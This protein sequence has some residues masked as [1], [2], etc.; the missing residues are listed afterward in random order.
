M[1][2]YPIGTV[3]LKKLKKNHIGTEG[4]KLNNKGSLSVPCF[5]GSLEVIPPPCSDPFR[6]LDGDSLL[7]PGGE[8]G[9]SGTRRRPD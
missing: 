7:G 6:D 4:N 1:S 8:P 5:K 2:Y 9:E 3:S